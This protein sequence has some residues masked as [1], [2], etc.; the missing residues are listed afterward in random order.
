MFVG[1]YLHKTEFIVNRINPN[2]IC[3]SKDCYETLAHLKI[4]HNLKVKETIKLQNNFENVYEL[5]DKKK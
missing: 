5:L 1:S 2:Q 4:H 3:I